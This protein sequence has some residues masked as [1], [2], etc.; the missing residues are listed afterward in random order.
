MWSSRQWKHRHV[1]ESVWK[2]ARNQ[3][4]HYRRFLTQ[5]LRQDHRWIN[6]IR[7]MVVLLILDIVLC[8]CAV[9]AGTRLI[10]TW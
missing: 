10:E 2:R 5:G 3:L 1:S 6:L 7:I 4:P 9:T 8:L